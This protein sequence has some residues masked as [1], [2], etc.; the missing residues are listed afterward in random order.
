[1]K[2]HHRQGEKGVQG[3]KE[4]EG[5]G[6]SKEVKSRGNVQEKNSIRCVSVVNKCSKH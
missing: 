6:R 2:E 5:E 4:G 1:M 3:Q